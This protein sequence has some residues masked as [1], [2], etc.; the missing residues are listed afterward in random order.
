MNTSITLQVSIPNT[1]LKT[2][3]SNPVIYLHIASENPETQVKVTTSKASKAS[4]TDRAEVDR[5]RNLAARR[6][7]LL[8]ELNSLDCCNIAC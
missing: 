7:A 5:V 2:D 1:E 4:K 3:R 8:Q 6:D